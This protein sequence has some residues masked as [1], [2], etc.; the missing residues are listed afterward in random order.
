MAKLTVEEFETAV[1]FPPKSAAPRLR[2]LGKMLECSRCLGSGKYSFTP[3]YGDRCFKC[4]GAGV[5]FPVFTKKLIEEVKT[6][7]ADGGLDE[8]FTQR[9][10]AAE[11]RAE[12]KNAE[13]MTR[14]ATK[15]ISD[16]YEQAYRIHSSDSFKGAEH[17]RKIPQWLFLAQTLNN[18]LI[19]GWGGKRIA[20]LGLDGLTLRCKN[21]LSQEDLLECAKQAQWILETAL[22]LRDEF[23]KL[24]WN[25]N[26]ED[27]Q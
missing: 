21:K 17:P 14:A 25:Y 24:A 13:K 4:Q 15:E 22:T 10:R 16:L 26:P 11:A 12:I 3:M 5:Q 18:E 8:Y 2:A 23:M 1:A 7:V 9:K 27:P 6:L 19:Y 20:T